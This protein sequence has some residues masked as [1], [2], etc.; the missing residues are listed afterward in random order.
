MAQLIRTFPLMAWPG[1]ALTLWSLRDSSDMEYHRDMPTAER[2]I[3]RQGLVPFRNLGE[4]SCRSEWL[5]PPYNEGAGIGGFAD[6]KN[7]C[8]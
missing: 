4:G 3:S 5:L 7:V 2:S 1:W 8:T 6:V